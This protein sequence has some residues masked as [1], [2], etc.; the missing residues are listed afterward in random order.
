MTT[1]VGAF[2]QEKALVG[3]FY[4]IVKTDGSFAALL[5]SYCYHC[6]GVQGPAVGRALTELL[7]EGEYKT[8]DLSRLGFQRLIDK[9]KMLERYCV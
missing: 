3:A 1:L 7:L 2:N 6:A 9:T 4:V 5:S 8:I